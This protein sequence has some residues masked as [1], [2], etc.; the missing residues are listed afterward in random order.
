V[1]AGTDEASV[2]DLAAALGWRRKQAELVLAE[3]AA[4]GRATQREDDGL[5]LWSA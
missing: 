4:T 2:A 5:Q 1:L 3:L